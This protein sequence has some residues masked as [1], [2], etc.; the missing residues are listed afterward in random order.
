MRPSHKVW[1]NAIR[2]YPR[3]LVRRESSFQHIGRIA[4]QHPFI[5]RTR[6]ATDN[7]IEFVL[8]NGVQSAF[9]QLKDTPTPLPLTPLLPLPRKSGQVHFSRCVFRKQG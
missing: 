7:L 1:P 9:C 4:N 2:V 3:L 8:E 6:V 5:P